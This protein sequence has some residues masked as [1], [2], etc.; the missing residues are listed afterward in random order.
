MKRAICAVLALIS[1]FSLTGCSANETEVE[2]PAFVSSD[3]WS[4]EPESHMITAPLN[5]LS[6]DENHLMTEIRN[7]T[8]EPGQTDEEAVIQA[9]IDGPTD[10]RSM[11]SVLSAS[12]KL[13]SV[14]KT[15][16]VINVELS[17]NY[18]YY[19]ELEMLKVRAALANTLSSLFDVDYI[20]VYVDG[21]DPGYQGMP[22]GAFKAT[23]LDLSLFC[24][25]IIQEQK[26][27]TDDDSYEERRIITYYVPDSGGTLLIA[28]PEEDTI[29]TVSS[30]ETVERNYLRT[31]LFGLMTGERASLFNGFN[32][33]EEPMVMLDQDGKRS[34]LVVLKERPENEILAYGALVY[35]VTGFVCN[36]SSVTI[37]VQDDSALGY[38][39]VTHVD[40]LGDFV[41]GEFKRSDFS[42]YI[43]D[44]ITLYA[45]DAADYSLVQYTAAV[46]QSESGDPERLLKELFSGNS[47]PDGAALI[48][49]DGV[50][51][52]DVLSI[53]LCG[54]VAVVDLSQNFLAGCSKLDERE[55]YLLVYSIVNTLT[56]LSEITSVQ[57][58]FEG[59]TEQKL[60]KMDVSGPLLRNPGL[61]ANA[62]G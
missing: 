35:S 15:G 1:A 20:N 53:K 27:I 14:E 26:K 41:N 8:V 50:G 38:E 40:G 37:A 13:V 29:D 9:L 31:V 25:Q 57:F 51:E 18:T 48:L 5:F 36:I 32:L 16:R 3:A 21:M 4:K 45:P 55:E 10:T 56:E 30:G 59:M 47:L 17:A 12:I 52:Q 22:L 2:R 42:G 11:R 49:P 43:G 23:T 60:N 46:P 39:L 44:Y 7:I 6:N 28:D 33:A 58:T 19:S 34:A 54:S 61:I 62:G 24:D